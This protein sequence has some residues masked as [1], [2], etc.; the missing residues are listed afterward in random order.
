MFGTYFGISPVPLHDPA[1]VN[2]FFGNEAIDGGID[3]TDRAE[4]YVPWVQNRG[5]VE[6]DVPRHLPALP[7]RQRRGRRRR[8]RARGTPISPD[9]TSGC[10]GAAPNGARGCF[11]CADRRGRRRRRRLRRHRRRLVFGQPGR[12]DRSRRARPGPASARSSL[13]NRP[14]DPDRRRPVELA[15]R[16]RRRTAGSARRRRATPATCS[17]RPTADA[18]WTQHQRQPAGRAGQLGRA[19]PVDPKTLY[20]GTDVGAFVTTNGGSSWQRLGTGCRRW[21]PGSSTTTPAT[22]CSLAGTHGRGAYT[23]ADTATPRRRSSCRRPTPGVPVGRAARSTTRSRCA[24]SATP[25]RP[26][27]P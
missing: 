3:L 6:P 13:P 20:V 18:T 24:T 2:T 19:R 1:H 14:V 9:L 22:A 4:F 8:R 12:G 17:R 16:L 10:T 27:S 25:T 21:R 7:H 23:L 5:N 26:T 15:D 11:I